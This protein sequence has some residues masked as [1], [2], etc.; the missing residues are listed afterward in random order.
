MDKEE[1]IVSISYTDDTD[2]ITNR[3]NGINKIKESI[4]L[5]NKCYSATSSKIE[6]KKLV[7]F[8]W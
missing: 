4:T 5:Y 6:I 3:E 8:A 1:Q 2:L 7:Y